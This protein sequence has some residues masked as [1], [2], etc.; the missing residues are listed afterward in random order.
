MVARSRWK[1]PYIATTFFVKQLSKTRRAIKTRIR[2]S[3][4][5]SS[6]TSKSF[7]VYNGRKYLAVIV[8]P[9]MKGFKLGEF[10]FTKVY[11]LKKKKKVKKLR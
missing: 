11:G 1:V 5:A 2:N 8:K 10:S 9:S 4:I 6:L 3:T 7:Y